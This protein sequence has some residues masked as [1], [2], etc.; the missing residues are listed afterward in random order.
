MPRLA[1][2]FLI[3]TLGL[4]LTG[5]VAL[6][7]DIRIIPVPPDVKPQWTPIPGASQVSWAPNIPTDVFRYRGKYYF[8]WGNYFYRGSQPQGPWKAVKKIPQVFYNIDPA[9]FKTANQGAAPTAPAPAIE[10]GLPKAKVIEIP[11]ATPR[12]EAPGPAPEAS[13]VPQEPA[14]APPKVM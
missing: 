12:D 2:S 13:P 4:A 10:P 7:Q 9:Y 5:A 3:L 8:F 6:A 14:P 11:P 1:T